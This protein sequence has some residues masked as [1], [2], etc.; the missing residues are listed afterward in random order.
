MINLSQKVLLTL[1][2]GLF[3]F[4]SSFPISAAEKIKFSIE[5]LGDFDISVRSLET[6]AQEGKITPEFAFYT[7]YLAPEELKKFR[8]LLNKSFP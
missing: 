8:N 1:G 7:K 5:P 4:F 3:F 6:F 2:F